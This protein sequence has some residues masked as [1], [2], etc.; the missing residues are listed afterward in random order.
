MLTAKKNKLFEKIFAGYN[1]NLFRRRFESLQISGFENLQNRSSLSPLI[2]YVNHSSWWDGLVAFEI[3]RA[4]KLD[5]FVMME[6]KQLKKLF[7]FRWLGAFSVVRDKPREAIKSINYAVEILTENKNRALWIFPQGEI[8][9][10][11]LRPIM[12][13]NGAAKIIEKLENCLAIP[14]AVRYEF[15][16]E[17]KPEIFVK[18][19]KLAELKK[20]DFID[21]KKLTKGFEQNMTKLLDELKADVLTKNL[22]T[23]ENII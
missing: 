17:F 14:I 11:D 12:F 8:A 6:E 3:S 5:S 15:L 1:R 10:N 16:G 13:F 18:I 23:Y 4:A 9:P 22:D 2:I 19:G 21:A 20:R 7:P